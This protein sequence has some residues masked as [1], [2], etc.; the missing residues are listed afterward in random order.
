MKLV[1]IFKPTFLTVMM[2]RV[3]GPTLFQFFTH[4]LDFTF[5]RLVSVVCSNLVHNFL[6]C[7][8]NIE[9]TKFSSIL[10]LLET[11][12]NYFSVL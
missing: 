12:A 5:S 10:K 1:E 6:F 8:W 11:V 2:M 9:T 7:T 3:T 4:L